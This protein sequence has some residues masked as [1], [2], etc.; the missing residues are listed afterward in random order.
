MI[1]YR[2]IIIL[3]FLSLLVF[4]F[5]VSFLGSF[6]G[7]T[8]RINLFLL[9]IILFFVFSGYKSSLIFSLCSGLVMDIFSFY[10]FGLFTLS[11]LCTLFLADFVWN[12]FFTNRSIYSFL[13][14]SFFLVFFYNIFLYFLIFLFEK[15]YFG[16][17][18]FNRFFWLNLFL[19]FIWIA[20]F[21]ILSFYFF[22]SNKGVS[23]GLVFEKR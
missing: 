21:M 18:W 22:G 17:F 14:L 9:I 19:E 5:Q 13:S 3:F 1:R 10:P 20:F 4:L 12:N 23:S 7:V 6:S 8:S 15:N 11:F 16:V 2:R